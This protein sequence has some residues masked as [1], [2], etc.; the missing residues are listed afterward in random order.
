[1]GGC[2][3]IAPKP[4]AAPIEAV[5]VTQEGTA[6]AF[7]LGEHT[8]YYPAAFLSPPSLDVSPADG[9]G[10][11]MRLE[12]KTDRFVVV[13]TSTE[14]GLHGVTLKWKARGPVPKSLAGAGTEVPASS[15]ATPET[16]K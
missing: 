6:T 14:I 11:I 1:M 15:F 2:A 10:V 12:Q 9:K 8:V 16:P 7:G 3:I 13:A 4:P 5:V